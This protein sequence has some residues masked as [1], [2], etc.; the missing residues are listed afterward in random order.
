MV[1]NLR[2][3]QDTVVSAK[4]YPPARC[5]WW[6]RFGHFM[7]LEEV[8]AVLQGWKYVDFQLTM[9]M[10]VSHKSQIQPLAVLVAVT[11]PIMQLLACHS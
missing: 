2:D 1:R 5:W 6:M 10:T 11:L 4:I 8:K 3:L 7:V 9:L